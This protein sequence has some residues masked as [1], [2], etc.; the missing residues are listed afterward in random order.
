MM[1]SGERKL[2]GARHGFP[3]GEFNPICH[4]LPK[5][6]DRRRQTTTDDDGRRQTMTEPLNGDD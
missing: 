1:A 6:K 3:E 4:R 5:D 2:S